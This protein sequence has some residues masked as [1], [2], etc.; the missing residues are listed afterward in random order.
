M[1][2]RLPVFSELIKGNLFIFVLLFWC[3]AFTG[4]SLVMS[5]RFNEQLD[6]N[7][8]T[9]HALK[10]QT[11][12]HHEA[13]ELE[14]QLSSLVTALE[15]GN[16]TNFGNLS[17]NLF[18]FNPHF[19]KVELRDATGK[20]I[21]SENLTPAKEHR[22]EAHNELSPSVVMNF[23]K[24]EDQQKPYW[25]FSF[26]QDGARLLALMV[27]S[28]KKNGLLLVYIDPTSWIS[29]LAFNN[30]PRTVQV[31]LQE[32][33]SAGPSADN[34]ITLHMGL[35]G[36]DMPLMFKNSVA[37]PVG[38]DPS[39]GLILFLGLA[40]AALLIRFN[41]EVKRSKKARE[42]LA[43]QEMALAKQAQLSTLGEISTTLAHELN[44]PLATI[45]NYIAMCEIRLRQ[46]GY[47]DQT[48]EKSLND[49]RAQ[50][51]RAG[52][53]VQSIRNF[54]RKGHSAKAT[55]EIEHSIANL[56]PILK[57]LVKENRSS[58][59]VVTEPNL[60]IR[61]D[62]AL[63]EQILLNLCKNGLDA[64]KDTPI[65]KRK[66]KIQSSLV[67]RPAQKSLV[68][69]SVMDSGHGIHADD[70]GKLFDSFFTT[71]IEGMGIGLSLVKSLTESH[72]GQITWA[73]NPD[74]GVTFTLQFPQYIPPA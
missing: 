7:E 47:S 49:A 4:F 73:N 11:S 20:L 16:S 53:V 41:T 67:T 43:V 32:D 23:F 38:F 63:F 45:T 66:L 29:F 9:K 6:N 46:L 17:R 26:D 71:K 22:L 70:A 21:K 68:Q 19:T 62:P 5:F 42:Q 15:K 55:V 36:L 65:D 25:A 27:P 48:L 28:G 34:S 14:T 57:S 37:R 33:G 24:A 8:L 40:L 69:I 12:F 2:R 59:E 54:L 64:M 44:Q 72:G 50:A 1:L 51:L 30:L 60:C 56:L 35:T 52:E 18:A 10:F 3:V 58:I 61:I 74:Q 31:S 39:S 13:M